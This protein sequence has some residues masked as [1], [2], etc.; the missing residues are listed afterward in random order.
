MV[1]IPRP[2]SLRA[3]SSSRLP[4]SGGGATSPSTTAK[5]VDAPLE[6]VVIRT[7]GGAGSGAVVGTDSGG[8]GGRRQIFGSNRYVD[9][10]SD[11]GALSPTSAKLDA[12]NVSNESGGVRSTNVQVCVRVRPLLSTD[13]RNASNVDDD[14]ANSYFTLPSPSSRKSFARDTK[15]SFRHATPRKTAIAT[16]MRTHT[17]G[18]ATP[19]RSPTSQSNATT[20]NNLNNGND[21]LD[22]LHKIPAWYT[23]SND[24]QIISQAAHTLHPTSDPSRAVTYTFDRV[25]SPTDSN[26]FSIRSNRNKQ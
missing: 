21:A 20:D 3:P 25:Y 14:E 5:V 26:W 12:N 11:G 8:S 17:S 13:F 23:S 16:P 7:D 6:S 15:S 10:G 19:L 4:T 1:E 24:I 18:L 2:S 22:N 9:R